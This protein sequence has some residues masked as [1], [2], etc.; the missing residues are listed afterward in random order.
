VTFDVLPG[1]EGE[2]EGFFRSQYAPAMK[3]QPGFGGFWLL[4]ESEASH[5]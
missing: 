5:R 4:K 1:K 2:L 3:Q